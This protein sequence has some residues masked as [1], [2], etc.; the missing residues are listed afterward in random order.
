V[1]V[2]WISE[3]SAFVSLNRKENC[4]FVLSALNENTLPLGC[5]VVSYQ[6]YMNL[7][8][9][10]VACSQGAEVQESS[11]KRSVS[12]V[13]G[14]SSALPSPKKSRQDSENPKLNKAH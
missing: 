9:K 2:D 12:L 8:H 4:Q 3:T 6:N 11:R 13:H 14:I 1:R 10:N 5:S 7:K